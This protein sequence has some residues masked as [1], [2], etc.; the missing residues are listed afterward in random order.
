MELFLCDPSG[1][2]RHHFLLFR[3]IIGDMRLVGRKIDMQRRLVR[4]M[5]PGKLKLILG[6]ILDGKL[7]IK[8]PAVP[9]E[10]H[11][12]QQALHHRFF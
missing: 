5:H 1:R 8:R 6:R 10:L 3:V 7:A 9:S 4:Q 11:E 2:K 12:P